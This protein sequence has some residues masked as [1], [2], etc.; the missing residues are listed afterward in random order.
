M[1]NL[2]A[3]TVLMIMFRLDVSHSIEKLLL[4]KSRSHIYDL[5]IIS[6]SISVSCKYFINLFLFHEIKINMNIFDKNY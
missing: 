3:L 4:S 1:H 6:P 5:L 2:Y